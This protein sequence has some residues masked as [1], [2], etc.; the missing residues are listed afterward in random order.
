MFEESQVRVRVEFVSIR[1]ELDT[2]TKSVLTQNST[3]L[4]SRLSKYRTPSEAAARA[5][6]ARRPEQ[7]WS[8]R[9]TSDPAP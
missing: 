2:S 9:A 3:K 1:F 4:T 6:A 7:P 5:S 8:G